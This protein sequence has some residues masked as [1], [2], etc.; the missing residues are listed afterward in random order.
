M[1]K[2][3]K[4]KVPQTRCNPKS[5]SR[6]GYLREYRLCRCMDEVGRWWEVGWNFVVTK[7]A[8]TT[9]HPG[10][11]SF[12]GAASL[13]LPCQVSRTLPQ[14]TCALHIPPP[15][16]HQSFPW[17]HIN[18]QISLD[19]PAL[20]SNPSTLPGCCAARDRIALHN[21]KRAFAHRQFVLSLRTQSQKQYFIRSFLKCDNGTCQRSL[22][23]LFARRHSESCHCPINKFQIPIA[24][25]AFWNLSIWSCYFPINKRVQVAPGLVRKKPCASLSISSCDF[26]CHRTVSRGRQQQSSITCHVFRQAHCL[27]L[28]FHE[29]FGSASVIPGKFHWYL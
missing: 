5:K 25:T 2:V 15:W 6:R 8:C 14:S 20:K 3:C 18:H 12:D 22:V 10:S 29:N 4:I 7:R 26:S 24:S 9:Q 27:R 21:A 1:P 16:L 28:A 17:H 19:P 13:W 11:F 23:S